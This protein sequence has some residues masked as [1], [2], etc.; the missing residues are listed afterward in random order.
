MNQQ[1]LQSARAKS[2]R[3]NAQPL[4]TYDDAAA[5]LG[6]CGICLFLPRHVQ[7]PAPAPSFVEACMGQTSAVPPANAITTAMDF[8]V[9]LIDAG[10]ALPLNLLGTFSEQPDFLIA[11]E[12]LPWVV[13]IRG[14]RQWKT[15]PSGHVAPIVVRTWEALEKQGAQTAVEIRELLGRELTEAAVLRA[16]IELWT[17]LRAIP[18]YVAGEPTRWSLLKE[19]FAPQ[20]TV[21][22][23]TGLPTALSAVLSLYLRSAVAATAEEA[24][25]FLSPLTAR[26]RI[27]DVIHGMTA[28]RQFATMSVGTE[29]L[30]FVAGTLPDTIP[31]AQPSENLT[32]SAAEKPQEARERREAIRKRPRGEERAPRTGPGRPPRREFRP[33]AASRG[34]GPRAARPGGAPPRGDRPAPRPFPIKHDAAPGNAPPAPFAD[35][36]QP[37]R[38]AATRPPA[39]RPAAGRPGFSSDRPRERGDRPRPSGAKPWQRR[40]ASA[41][42][43]KRRDD[44][45]PFPRREDAAPPVPG[46]KRPWPKD[47]PKFPAKP[48]DRPRDTDRPERPARPARPALPERS[49]RPVGKRPPRPAGR[50]SFNKGPRPAFGAK[51]FERPRKEDRPRREPRPEGAAPSPAPG[52]PAFVRKFPGGPRIDAPRAGFSR[53]PSTAGPKKRTFGSKGPAKFSRSASG[54]PKRGGLRPGAN[55]RN[56]FGKSSRP[57]ERKPRKNRKQD[58][59][60]E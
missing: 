24:E 50:P 13:A 39:V 14:D 35:Q 28:A 34:A 40:S 16:L 6:E 55:P 25:I 38:P 22:A 48:V 53:K 18:A 2:W 29:T 30:L 43:A 12:V 20:L 1:Q 17:S 31:E 58:E 5:W 15:A 27:R 21:A 46:G 42:P 11:P 54:P 10:R 45:P 47:R 3:Q 33:A 49:D 44:K 36:N 4:L 8:A 41:F 19:R 37:S 59:K 51:R 56:K 32:L 57:G 9:R 26:S 52:A 7:L 60:P 23:S